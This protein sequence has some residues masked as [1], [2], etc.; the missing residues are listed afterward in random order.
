MEALKP[1]GNNASAELG[2]LVT[3]IGFLIYDVIVVDNYTN[4]Q[5]GC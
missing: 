5:G 1:V 2:A 3:E 4:F